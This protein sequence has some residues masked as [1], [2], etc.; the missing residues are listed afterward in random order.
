MPTTDDQ[1]IHFEAVTVEV[2]RMA[3]QPGDVVI[4]RIPAKNYSNQVASELHE[5]MREDL[6][7]N[8]VWVLPDDVEISVVGSEDAEADSEALEEET[9]EPSK[10]KTPDEWRE[11]YDLDIRDPDGWRTNDAPPWDQPIGLPEFWERFNQSTV[12]GLHL[13]DYE[14]IVADVRAAREAP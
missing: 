7:D 12:R 1:R 11:L 2:A 5:W 13:I 6:P 14:R 10:L 8:R 9:G 3:V 4:V